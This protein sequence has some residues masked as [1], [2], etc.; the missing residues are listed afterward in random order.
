MEREGDGE[1]A[2]RRGVAA[3]AFGVDPSGN[4]FEFYHGRAS[5]EEA[6]VPSIAGISFVTDPMGLGHLV[7]P[8]SEFDATDAFYRDV[9]GFGLSDSLTLP[10]AMEGA[11][12]QRLKFLHADNPRHHSLGLY[13]YPV[14]SGVAH[15]MAEVDSLDN[16]G[17]CLDRAKAAGAPIIA[18]LGRHWNDGMVSFYMIG[19]GGIPIEYGFGGRQYDWQGYEPT[20]G[21]IPDIWGHEFA[22]P[23]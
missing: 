11:P 12:E 5:A 20:E 22:F 18:S 1:E 15:V 2:R 10:P 14:P 8:A 23:E 17:L 7:L 19:P 6:F 13:N 21:S 9:L 16:V 4:A 3:V